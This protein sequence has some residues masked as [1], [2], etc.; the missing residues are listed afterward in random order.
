MA[1]ARVSGG[2]SIRRLVRLESDIGQGLGLSVD[3]TLR[4]TD[5]EPGTAA[6][7]S[8]LPVG[9]ILRKIDGEIAADVAVV[10]QKL[11]KAPSADVEVD[12]DGRLPHPVLDPAPLHSGVVSGKKLRRLRTVPT[13]D[14]FVGEPVQPGE[15]LQVF[16]VK[17]LFTR[18]RRRAKGGG[19]DGYLR[20]EYISFD[21]KAVVAAA[22]QLSQ[23]ARRRKRSPEPEEDIPAPPPALFGQGS[24]GFKEGPRK[25]T[26]QEAKELKNGVWPQLPVRVTVCSDAQEVEK[27]LQKVAV[28]ERMEGELRS[29][30]RL[31]R[32]VGW[33]WQPLGPLA[34]TLPPIS[35]PGRGLR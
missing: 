8:G 4:V 7:R 3:S 14:E 20:T 33:K 15:L 22:Q 10:R 1:K 31:A 27:E 2:I 32:G 24:R 9:A 17:D 5:T 23:T 16:G 18:V 26:R 19:E 35:S 6:G 34:P 11:R 12:F 30:L 21:S 13:K 25:V 28:F 29:W